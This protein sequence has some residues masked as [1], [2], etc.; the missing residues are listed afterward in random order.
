MLGIY[1]RVD[2]ERGV[3]KAPANEVVRGILGLTRY[4]TKG[5]QEILNPYPDNINIVAI[6]DRT[7]AASA[8]GARA[9][10]PATTTTSMSTFA[11]C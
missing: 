10:S 3:H 9:A 8:C 7:T 4:F 2:N 6:S 11:A 5:E 1:A